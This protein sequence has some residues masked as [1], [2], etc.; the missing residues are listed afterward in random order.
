MKWIF[1]TEGASLFNFQN[2]TILGWTAPSVGASGSEPANRATKGR[3]D[4]TSAPTRTARCRIQQA[5]VASYSISRLLYCAN[6][7]RPI[8]NEG[9]LEAMRSRVR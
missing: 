1:A 6:G 8:W 5:Q 3:P 4:A 9:L 7:T 2:L